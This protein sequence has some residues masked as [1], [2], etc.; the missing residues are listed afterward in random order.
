MGGWGEVGAGCRGKVS[1][2]RHPRC[3]LRTGPDRILAA[4]AL[5]TR[6]HGGAQGAGPAQASV[7]A[8]SLDFRLRDWLTMG[9]ARNQC[10]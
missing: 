10:P 7:G 8:S 4:D 6:R 9:H 5:V 3:G 2:R 1:Q